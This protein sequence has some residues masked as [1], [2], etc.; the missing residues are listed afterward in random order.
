MWM[1][2]VPHIVL[3][4]YYYAVRVCARCKDR[5]LSCCEAIPLCF[6]FYDIHVSKLLFDFLHTVSV[7]PDIKDQH[8]IVAQ[9]RANLSKIGVYRI[10]KSPRYQ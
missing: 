5:L 2:R 9:Q 1:V 3:L 6:F 10:M 4:D 8:A 7:F